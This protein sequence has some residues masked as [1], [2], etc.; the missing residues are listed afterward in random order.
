M[1]SSFFLYVVVSLSLCLV[2][3]RLP[4]DSF[5]SKEIGCKL[6]CPLHYWS[7][8]NAFILHSELFIQS[9][10]NR[11]KSHVIW[12]QFSEPPAL[13]TRQL[14]LSAEPWTSF[15]LAANCCKTVSNK[16]KNLQ[17]CLPLFIWG[18]MAWCLAL[19]LHSEKVLVRILASFFL[20]G[21]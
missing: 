18:L 4:L 1:V 2:V 6:S 8:I 15:L 11:D 13:I 17:G 16:M 19:F 7:C 9:F 12:K 14:A 5:I 10:V 21:V 20:C 3:V